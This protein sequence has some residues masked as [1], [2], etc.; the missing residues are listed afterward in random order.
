[1]FDDLIGLVLWKSAEGN[2]FE[3]YTHGVEEL[4]RVGFYLVKSLV[5]GATEF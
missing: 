5:T 1:M 2:H 4:Q 3:K